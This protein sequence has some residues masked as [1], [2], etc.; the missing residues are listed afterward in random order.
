MLAG[1]LMGVS[2]I[3]SQ[4]PGL[5]VAHQSQVCVVLGSPLGTRN[6][7]F[8]AIGRCFSVVKNQIEY[9]FKALRET[10]NNC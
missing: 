4:R 2:V 9:W 1:W 3:L 10:D 7:A 6:L 5:I 8:T